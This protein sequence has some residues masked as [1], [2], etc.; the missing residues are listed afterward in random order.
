MSSTES[1]AAPSRILP[2]VTEPY[3]FRRALR[4]T[5][6]DATR[7]V[8]MSL[9]RGSEIERFPERARPGEIERLRE[10]ALLA[11]ASM[12]EGGGVP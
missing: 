7:I 3:L 6:Q 11:A 5:L 12:K 4:V 10:G 2:K 1:P 8:G 9:A